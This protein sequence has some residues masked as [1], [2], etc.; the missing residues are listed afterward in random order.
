MR[1]PLGRSAWLRTVAEEANLRLLNRYFETDPTNQVDQV[2]LLARP[3][4]RRMLY[5]GEGPIRGYYS[6]P[7][8]FDDASFTVSGNELWRVDTDGTK[9]RVGGGIWGTGLRGTV[10]MAATEELLFVAD[11]RILWV[12]TAD[13]YAQGVLAGTAADT[14]TIRIG[15]IYYRWTAG[16]VE[17]GT[18]E[19]SSGNPWLV[20]LGG[21]NAEA[22]DNMRKAIDGDG[23]PSVTYSFGLEPHPDVQAVTSTATSL[24]VQAIEAGTGGNAIVTTVIS[25]AGLAWDAATLEDGGVPTFRQVPVP[26]D[27]GIIS[28]GYIGGFVICVVAQGFGFNGRFYWIEPGFTTID[29]LNFATAERA[30]DPVWN[31]LVVGD[32]FWLPGS[33]TN[34]VWYPTGDEAIPFL[35]VQGRLFDQGTWEG[36]AIVIR[37]TTIMTDPNGAVWRNDGAGPRRISTPA[38]EERIRAAIQ[39]QKQHL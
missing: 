23:T 38:I 20:A 9:V 8:A 34:E 25:G 16:S 37:D 19:G 36:T 13:G 2:A 32:Q 30:P 3:P 29:P 26:D 21:T 33:G 6:Q 4:L 1:I 31:V 10:S 12:Y 28:V 11:G 39:K 14:D 15:S 18:P 24:T 22:L 5:V 27:V 7:G 35:R 17:A